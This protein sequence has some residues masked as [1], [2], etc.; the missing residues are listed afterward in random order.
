MENGRSITSRKIAKKT[1]TW[2]CLEWTGDFLIAA[3]LFGS[4]GLWFEVFILTAVHQPFFAAVFALHEYMWSRSKKNVGQ[5]VA[6]SG[7]IGIGNSSDIHLLASDIS[8]NDLAGDLGIL[9]R[10]SDR[11]PPAQR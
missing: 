3:L 9:A 8:G 10:E 7:R 5:S 2:I 4:H 11:K 6:L 1:A